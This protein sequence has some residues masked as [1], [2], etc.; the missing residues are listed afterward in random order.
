MLE[1]IS[2]HNREQ[3]FRGNEAFSPM[4]RLLKHGPVSKKPDILFG[5]AVPPQS[6]NER[7][8]ASAFSGSQD[9]SASHHSMPPA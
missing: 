5:E 8:K 2:A 4:K 9:N 7:L 1:V 6:L 3:P